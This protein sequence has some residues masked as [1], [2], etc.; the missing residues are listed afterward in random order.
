M[1]IPILFALFH[2]SQKLSNLVFLLILR[3]QTYP[4]V[5]KYKLTNICILS[6][7]P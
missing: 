2:S 4:D 1:M 5:A 7:D 3:S 6:T